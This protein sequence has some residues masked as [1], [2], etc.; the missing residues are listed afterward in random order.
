[1][2]AAQ[3]QLIRKIADA[4]LAAVAEAGPLG[5]PGGHLYAALMAHGATLDQYESFMAGLVRAGLVTK[6]GECY[7]ITAAGRREVA[8]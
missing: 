8:R 4:I 5:A 2:T 3:D 7:H 1:M 6:R